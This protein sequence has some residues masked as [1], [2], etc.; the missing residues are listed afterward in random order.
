M[1]QTA[2]SRQQTADSRQQTADSRQQ[3]ADSRQQ[4]ADSRQQT[5]ESREQAADSRQQTADSRQQTEDSGQTLY[6]LLTSCTE[7]TCVLGTM[8]KREILPTVERLRG[9]AERQMITSGCRPGDSVRMW[10]RNGYGVT[11]C[12]RV[13]SHPAAD[14]VGDTVIVFECGKE[15]VMVLQSVRKKQ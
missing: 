13:T 12:Q 14:L 1:M 2:D 10:E 7:R 5:S 11:E 8:Q 9:W 4:T 15:T 6:R 3:T